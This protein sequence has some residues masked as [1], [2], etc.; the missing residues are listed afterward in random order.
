MKRLMA[1]CRSTTEWKAP[2]FSRLFVSLAKNPST[3]FS[4][5]ADVGV[6]W[7]LQRG[8]RSSQ[9]ITSGVLCVETLS[10]T[11]CTTFPA[12]MSRS[13]AFRNRMNS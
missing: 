8:W 10:N 2:Y 6:K 3:A 4:Q 9:R 12:G 11:T 5:E 13:S 1:A 7:K